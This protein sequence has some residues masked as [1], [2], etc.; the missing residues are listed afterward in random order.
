MKSPPRPTS[1]KVSEDVQLMPPPPP[2]PPH[3]TKTGGDDQ[4]EKHQQPAMSPLTP[5]KTL[6]ESPLWNNKVRADLL[7][8]CIRSD[9]AD[10]SECLTLML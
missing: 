10:N 3:R 6:V 8:L 4:N 9:L 5:L 2:P 7:I 1:L